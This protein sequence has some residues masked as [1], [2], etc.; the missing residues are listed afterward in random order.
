MSR[1]PSDLRELLLPA[2]EA[3]R[4][5]L[6]ELSSD[7]VPATLRRVAAHTGGKLP[8]PLAGSVLAALD[9]DEWMREK[10]AEKLERENGSGAASA[11]IDRG[12]RW[13][14][15]VADA[16]GD[17]RAVAADALVEDATTTAEALRAKLVVAK[18]RLKKIGAEFEAEKAKS[19]EKKPSPTISQARAEEDRKAR[20][21]FKQLEGDLSDAIQDRVEAEAMIARLRTRLKS[22]LR[23]QR[24]RE[25][26][27]ASGSSFGGGPVEAA[28]TLDLLAAAAPDHP[29]DSVVPSADSA[30]APAALELPRG[31]RPDAREA[32]DWL[33]TIDEA[34]TVIVDGYNVLYSLDPASFT[35]GK[36]R[37]LF[38]GHLSRLRRSAGTARV[39]VVYDSDLPGDR[40][41]RT[42]PGGVEMQFAGED[43]LADDRIVEIAAEA[44]GSVV[45]ITSDRDLRD[46]SEAVGA[47]ALWS[48]ALV[49]WI[50]PQSG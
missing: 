28:R 2:I 42:L 6:R 34:I 19:R 41:P 1:F 40:E 32:V 38:A 16:L 50:A 39:V 11:F 13:W 14:V 26:A 27:G 8:P 30:F 47:F 46:R 24:G 20:A 12:D 4:S 29:A 17:S 18:D 36:S 33:A 25:M 10:A 31:V 48:E 37:E 15:V 7:E 3:T 49:G 43:Q 5:A 22:A 45:V 35:T 23:E 44:R 9:E 21:R